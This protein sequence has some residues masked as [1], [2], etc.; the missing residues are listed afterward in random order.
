MVINSRYATYNSAGA[1]G[2]GA[3]P[4]GKQPRGQSVSYPVLPER[5]R[6][7]VLADT[8][9]NRN[10]PRTPGTGTGIRVLI[11]VPLLT[12]SSVPAS[13]SAPYGS[14]ETRTR[15][16]G[17]GPGRC[18]RWRSNGTTAEHYAEHCDYRR[19]TQAHIRYT[20]DQRGTI[21]SLSGLL[22]IRGLL[23]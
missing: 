7:R 14:C 18:S 3:P 20:S 4:A 5:N 12:A 23:S 1:L 13:F 21:S 17:P 6:N 15:P 2:R 22:L 8:P 11:P 19:S 10:R 9:R 16:G